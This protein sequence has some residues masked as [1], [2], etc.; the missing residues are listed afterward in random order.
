MQL[1]KKN[2]YVKEEK[3]DWREKGKRRKMWKKVWW[4][5]DV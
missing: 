4:K 1:E 3:D 5:C 2:V